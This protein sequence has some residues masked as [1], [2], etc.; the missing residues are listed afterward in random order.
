MDLHD[1]SDHREILLEL[2]FSGANVGDAASCHDLLR[3]PA[4]TGDQIETLLKRHSSVGAHHTFRRYR[5]APLPR[6]SLLTV[7][8]DSLPR[9][10]ACSYFRLRNVQCCSTFAPTHPRRLEKFRDTSSLS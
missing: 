7:I 9:L 1:R 2:L 4:G 10:A 5:V 3:H 8:R 6:F